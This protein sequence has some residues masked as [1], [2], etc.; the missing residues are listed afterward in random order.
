MR[1]GRPLGLGAAL[2]A[3]GM[4]VG[5]RSEPPPS[6]SPA[7]APAPSSAATEAPAPPVIAHVSTEVAA[8]IVGQ[9]R[10]APICEA[11]TKGGSFNADTTYDAYVYVTGLNHHDCK[12]G[13][14]CAQGEDDEDIFEDLAQTL[15]ELTPNK[16][17]FI[18]LLT[19]AWTPGG[20]ITRRDSRLLP[21]LQAHIPGLTMR[22][23]DQYT[24]IYGADFAEATPFRFTS[25][26][27]PWGSDFAGYASIGLQPA[28]GSLWRGG[29]IDLSVFRL[30]L[31]TGD[32]N[33][34][35]LE[36]KQ[37]QIQDLRI[38]LLNQ[39]ALGRTNPIAV[40]DTNARVAWASADP[41]ATCSEQGDPGGCLLMGLAVGA[42]RSASD[43]DWV[44]S[45][46][47]CTNGG[48]L[49]AGQDGISEV[50][51]L[52]T[53]KRDMTKGHF[54]AEWHAY[55]M[56]TGISIPRL[57]HP[58]I[59]F[60]LRYE[61]PEACNADGDCASCGDATCIEGQCVCGS[62]SER[63]GICD[64]V[65]FN[66]DHC[67]SCFGPQCRPDQACNGGTCGCSDGTVDCSPGSC[68]PLGTDANCGWCGDACKAGR[69]VDGQCRS[70]TTCKEECEA[71]R[72]ICQEGCDAD[73]QDSGCDRDCTTAFKKC[74]KKCGFNG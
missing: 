26:S 20:S 39:A 72:V 32:G 17:R 18:L 19:G 2:L 63:C 40:G 59:G 53:T 33:V 43:M 45:R 70:G 68:V 5:C 37:S 27:R 23:S 42:E 12:G 74:T 71:E 14:D 57:G 51:N 6:P 62:G 41:S 22:S 65:N 9:P 36:T 47:A 4:L 30:C 28:L 50:I 29:R 44:T 46:M 73:P 16:R 56:P 10:G 24:V 52:I 38:A 3:W 7:P 69:C 15:A 60:R 58:V 13:G 1:N 35:D 31:M 49:Y 8:A 48:E 66:P 64:R 61:C 25:W 55:N 11:Y 21:H 34:C 67:G 54:A